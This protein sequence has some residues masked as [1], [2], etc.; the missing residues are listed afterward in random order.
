[1]PYSRTETEKSSSVVCQSIMHIPPAVKPKYAKQDATCGHS[2]IIRV[3]KFHQMSL[4]TV[5]SS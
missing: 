2:N 3:H 4:S 1:M 5:Y